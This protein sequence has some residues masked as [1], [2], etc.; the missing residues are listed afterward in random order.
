[1]KINLEIDEARNF[2]ALIHNLNR[3]NNPQ[4]YEIRDQFK[5]Y[6]IPDEMRKVIRSIIS[7]EGDVVSE[8]IN[9]NPTLKEIYQKNKEIWK[10]YWIKNKNHL[11]KIKQ[12]LQEKLNELNL[13][14]IKK[15]ADFFQSEIPSEIT[16]YLCM[17]ATN[18]FGRGTGMSDFVYIL[19][20]RNFLHFSKETI[21]SDFAVIIHEIIHVIQGEKY[22]QEEREIIEAV[23]RAFAPRGILIN[24][25]K[26]DKGSSEEKILPLI[27]K[28]LSEGKNYSQVKDQIYKTLKQV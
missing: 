25:N 14:E 20:P 4:E 17:G 12:E 13:V 28:A 23:T 18:M 7:L 6:L 5:N 16:F 9:K 8:E 19:F 27:L 2:L 21:E 3:K 1:M 10:E 22:Y 26:V 24:S 11:I 15:C